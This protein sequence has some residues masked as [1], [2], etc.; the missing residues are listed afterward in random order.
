MQYLI[1]FYLLID[2]FLI[3][4]FRLLKPP[5]LGFYLGNIVLSFFCVLIG[6]LTMVAI[7]RLNENYFDQ[8]NQEML[9]N[10]TLSIKAILFKSK[11]HYKAANTLANEAFGK[12]FFASLALFASSLWPIPFALGWLAFRFEEVTFPIWLTS[13]EFGY[14]GVFIPLYI[15][16]RLLFGKLK[17]HISWLQIGKEEVMEEV[18]SWQDLHKKE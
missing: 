1:K 3:Y 8:L 4:F 17:K 15:L 11:E 10:H 5:I 12:T 18:L 9:R 2:P 14:L 13:W 7:Y 16:V 6:E